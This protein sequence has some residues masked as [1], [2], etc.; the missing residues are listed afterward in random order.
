MKK[1]IKIFNS[2][3][4]QDKADENYYR[5][6]SPDKKILEL[7]YIRNQYIYNKYGCL[8]GL[9]RV[10]KIVKKKTKLNILL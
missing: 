4:E 7:E 5:K 1:V 3:E 8:P 6:L 9:R 2:H 10:Y